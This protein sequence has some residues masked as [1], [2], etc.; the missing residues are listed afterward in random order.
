[1]FEFECKGGMEVLNKMTRECLEALGFGE[2]TSFAEGKY[3]D[4]AK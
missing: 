1:M 2:R 4:M 3:E